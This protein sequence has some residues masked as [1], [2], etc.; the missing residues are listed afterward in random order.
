MG[1]YCNRKDPD[2]RKAF[3]DYFHFA[4]EF[5][6]YFHPV[7]SHAEVT[8]VFPRQSVLAGDDRPVERFRQTGQFLMDEHVFFDVL[9]DQKI[10]AKRR[11]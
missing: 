10:L 6:G 1:L 8:L 4:E 7:K 9:S 2:G 11:N 5:E 3:I